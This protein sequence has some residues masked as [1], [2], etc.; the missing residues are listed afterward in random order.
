[1]IKDFVCIEIDA[2]LELLSHCLDSVESYCFANE[3][4]KP[5]KL[6]ESCCHTS[7]CCLISAL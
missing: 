3:S 5:L 2:D 7:F 6:E 4:T 1:M